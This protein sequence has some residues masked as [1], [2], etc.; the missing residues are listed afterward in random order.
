MFCVYPEEGRKGEYGLW[1]KPSGGSEYCPRWERRL[2]LTGIGS[3]CIEVI[4]VVTTG[5]R[6]L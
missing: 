3:S 1:V 4:A 2:G 6:P 5:I